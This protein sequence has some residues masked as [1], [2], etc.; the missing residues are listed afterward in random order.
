MP[1]RPALLRRAVAEAIATFALVFAGCGAVIAN[2][3]YGGTLGAAGVSAAF[4]TAA[5]RRS[6]SIPAPD[7]ALAAVSEQAG[8]SNQ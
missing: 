3:R 8:R 4:G 7:E 6:S 1:E 2:A 5:S